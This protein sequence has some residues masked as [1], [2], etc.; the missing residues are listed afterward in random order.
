MLEKHVELTLKKAKETVLELLWPTR[1]AVCDEPGELICNTCTSNLIPYDPW[2][3]CPRCGAPWG[4][5]QCHLC[6]SYSAQSMNLPARD[7]PKYS[8]YI[9]QGGTASI[10]RRFKD[11]NEQRLSKLLAAAMANAL[12]PELCAQI[13]LIV[14]VPC[15]AASIQLR[16]FDQ[17]ELISADLSELLHKPALCPF[18]L[19]QSY[20]Q[21]ELNRQERSHNMQHAFQLN[22]KCSCLLGKVV[23]LIDDVITTGATMNAAGELLYYAGVKQVFGLSY[24]RVV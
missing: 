23:L 4:K 2:L 13:E 24:A 12:S 18:E 7:F 8:A 1:C 9:F 21:R 22:S 19:P 14:Y 6:N 3:A 16:G 17:M 10:V 20:D 5:F 15:S 11:A